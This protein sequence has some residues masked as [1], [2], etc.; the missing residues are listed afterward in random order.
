MSRSFVREDRRKWDAMLRTL[1]ELQGA[2]VKVGIQSDA[3]A[4]E[5]G[6]PLASI[7]FWN[8]FGTDG[9]GWGGPIPARPFLRDTSDEKRAEWNRVADRAINAAITGRATLRR[10]LEI[11]GTLAERDIKA[12][13]TGGGWTPNSPVTVALKGSSAPLIETGALRGAIRYE[14][15]L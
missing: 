6:T 2:E 11:L 8:E 3:G 1:P 7:A 5:D 12:G 10:G 13:F 14:V 9:G 4:S 15:R